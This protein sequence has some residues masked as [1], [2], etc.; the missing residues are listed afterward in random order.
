MYEDSRRDDARI[1]DGIILKYKNWLDGHTQ[2]VSVNGLMSKWRLHG[3]VLGPV[4]FNIFVGDLDSGIECT[5]SKF[6][7]DTKLCGPVNMLE[8]KDAIQRDLDR[9]ERWACAKLL[10]FNQAKCKVLHGGL[11]NPKN[12]YRLG[13][14]QISPS[15]ERLGRIVD[16]KL[17]VRQQCVLAAQKANWAA[18]K[19]VLPARPSSRDLLLPAFLLHSG[20]VPYIINDIDSADDTKLSG[21]VDML[22]GRD[23]IQK[24][25]DRFEE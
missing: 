21:T 8:G 1:S 20:T 4:L 14:E 25:L 23:A 9:L 17:N 5:L 13:G 6:S 22:E 18:S 7:H 12:K 19:K 2:R 10:K 3:S 15:G 16:E 11:C 24:D